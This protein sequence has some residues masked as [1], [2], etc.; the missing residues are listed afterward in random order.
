MAN[1]VFWGCL[2]ASWE[3]WLLAMKAM[4]AMKAVEVP[5]ETWMVTIDALVTMMGRN[6]NDETH[7]QGKTGEAETG[8]VAGNVATEIEIKIGSATT[9]TTVTETTVQPR[10][11]SW[12]M[13]MCLTEMATMATMRASGGGVGRA[14]LGMPAMISVFWLISWF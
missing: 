11:T 9:T 6:A 4:K 12:M 10:W 1:L 13:V 14:R 5:A 3:G 7:M 8:A 2:E